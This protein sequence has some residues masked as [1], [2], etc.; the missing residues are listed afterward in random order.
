MSERPLRSYIRRRGRLTRAQARALDEL[1]A[2]YRIEPPVDLTTAFRRDAQLAVEVGFGMGH[3]LLDWAEQRPD[4]NLLGL[5][6]YEPGIGALLNGLDARELEN[7][8]VMALP[9]EEVFDKHLASGSVAEVRVYFPDPWPKTRHHKRRL[10]QHEF[11]ACMTDRLAP[12]GKL[13]AATD[14]QPY[15]EWIM[16][17][18]SAQP[19][20]VNVR[21]AG[22]YTDPQQVRE[23]TRVVRETTRFEARGLRL[24]HQIF[25]FHFERAA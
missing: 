9:A 5:E 2:A 12:G 21:G 25:D 14:W 13:L 11:I 3:A 16:E 10:F 24:G 4:L 15:A 7:V 1:S 19:G 6:L 20:L 18:L 8:R 22:R 17:R 23:S